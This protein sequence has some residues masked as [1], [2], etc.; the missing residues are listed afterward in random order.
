MK[1]LLHGLFTP[2]YKKEMNALADG[3]QE[4]I[5]NATS[6]VKERTFT[7]VDLWSIQRRKKR[8]AVRRFTYA[9]I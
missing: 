4:D 6:E 5:A 3:A 1:K 7:T 2:V 9:E 8:I